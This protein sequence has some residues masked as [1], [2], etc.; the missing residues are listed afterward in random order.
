MITQARHSGSK[1]I[2]ADADDPTAFD[3]NG[4]L[5]DGYKIRV[6]ITMMDLP[7]ERMRSVPL[8][9]TTGLNLGKYYF[10]D[11]TEKP[12]RT[13][14]TERSQPV[15]DAD[16]YS[17]H[18]PGYRSDAGA[19]RVTVDAKAIAY[20]EMVRD[21][22]TAWMSPES[23]AQNEPLISDTRRTTA[24]VR[25]LGISDS[26]W[27]RHQMI[28]DQA[29]AWRT[30]DAP[31]VATPPSGAFAPVGLGANEGD[32]CSQNGVPGNLVR[33]G[34]WLFCEVTP[35]GATRSGTSRGD[36]AVGDR[37][38]QDQAWRA[39]VEEQQNAWRS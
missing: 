14:R 15:V 34:D 28:N 7:M 38:L 2:A 30:Q 31:A 32:I 4:F 29:N 25:P 35:L 16:P 33:R 10:P 23:K 18:K 6:P 9:I 20:D 11:G 36:A 5:R 13:P 8:S 1:Y 39:M 21:L 22:S 17:D 3:E 19:G 12:P 26:D 37:S 27:A 24:D